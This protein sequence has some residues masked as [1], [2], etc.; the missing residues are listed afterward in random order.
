MLP[1]D[2]TIFF[3]QTTLP[4]VSTEEKKNPPILSNYYAFSSFR[5]LLT[6]TLCKVR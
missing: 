4:F 2:E 5:F 1:K 3:S 6:D